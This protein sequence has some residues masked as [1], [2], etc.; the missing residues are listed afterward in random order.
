MALQNV[1]AHSASLHRA[2]TGHVPIFLAV[3]VKKIVAESIAA[4]CVDLAA[5]MSF[6]FVLALF[7]FS[8]ALAALVG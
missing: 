7:P 1:N 2:G 4:D 3:L 6:Y 8:L 5:Q